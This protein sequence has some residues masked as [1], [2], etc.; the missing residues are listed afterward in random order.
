MSCEDEFKSYPTINYLPCEDNNVVTDPNIISDFECQANF[1]FENVQTIRNPSETPLNNSKFVGI[2]SYTSNSNDFI[3]INYGYPI[4][5]SNKS[6]FKIKV[7][8][9]NSQWQHTTPFYD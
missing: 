6:V 4:N 5:L 2:Y 1:I 7:K 8:T 3:E 9:S